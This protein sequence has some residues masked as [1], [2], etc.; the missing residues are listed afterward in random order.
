ML[1]HV[2]VYYVTPIHV[3]I[4]PSFYSYK[5][6]Y[7]YQLSLIFIFKFFPLHFHF[8]N[9]WSRKGNYYSVHEAAQ[10]PFASFFLPSP[11]LINMYNYMLKHWLSL[12]QLQH[13]IF[14]ISAFLAWLVPDVPQSVKNEI[15]NEKLLAFEAIQARQDAGKD[16]E[17]E[18]DA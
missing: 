2:V 3:Y 13:I 4:V 14:I 7:E 1:L 9:V 17:I 11:S 18:G 6:H 5:K 8:V 10:F 15:Q 16:L 12:S